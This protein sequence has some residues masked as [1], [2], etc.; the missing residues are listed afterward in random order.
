V[1]LAGYKVLRRR[2]YHIDKPGIII[3]QLRAVEGVVG[4]EKNLIWQA[5]YPF[6]GSLPGKIS[7]SRCGLVSGRVRCQFCRIGR[8]LINSTE[9]GNF[10]KVSIRIFRSDLGFE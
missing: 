1:S 4:F 3:S 7:Y 2:T 6:T 8:K 9:R 5:A 10:Y